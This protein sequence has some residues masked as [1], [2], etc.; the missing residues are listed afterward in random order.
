MD[1][2]AFNQLANG[3]QR[4]SPLG[5]TRAKPINWTSLP[6]GKRWRTPTRKV[7]QSGRQYRT[8]PPQSQIWVGP[9][10]SP[11]PSVRSWYSCLSRRHHVQTVSTQSQ[12]N[13]HAHGPLLLDRLGFVMCHAPMCAYVASIQSH[14]CSSHTK[15]QCSWRLWRN[16]LCAPS[17][18]GRIDGYKIEP[19]EPHWPSGP[20]YERQPDGRMGPPIHG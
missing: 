10:C 19:K 15:A 7:A 17:H 8:N 18:H 9:A 11:Q 6:A 12:K 4:A 3:A 13:V 14:P 2:S 5:D 20:T 16:P 1:G